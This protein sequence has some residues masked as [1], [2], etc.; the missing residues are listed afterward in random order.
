[1]F[2]YLFILDL[3]TMKNDISRLHNDPSKKNNM[4]TIP[5]VIKEITKQTNYKEQILNIT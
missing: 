3:Q 4:F 5:K 1:M 2:I